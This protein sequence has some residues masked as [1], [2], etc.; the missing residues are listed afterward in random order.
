[1]PEIVLNIEQAAKWL[2]PVVLVAPGV[3]A[4]LLGLVIW[5]GGLSLR[6]FLMAVIGAAA[7]AACGFFIIGCDIVTSAVLAVLVSVIAA[8]V[9]RVFIVILAAIMAVAVGFAILAKPYF[10]EPAAMVLTQERAGPL[11]VEQSLDVVKTYISSCVVEAEQAGSEMP[12]Y[13]LAILAGLGVIF[14]IGGFVFWNSVSALCCAALG[15]MLVFAG[16]ILLLLYKGAAPIANIR[17]DKSFY[18]SVF[19]TMVL[20]GTALQLLL[21][22]Q[23]IRKQADLGESGQA[24]KEN[25]Q[26]SG[27]QQK[28]S[29]TG[30]RNR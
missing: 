21:F 27:H 8:L 22:R 1:M 3:T 15:T 7:A 12:F 18:T 25:D 2:K 23:G 10:E 5:L 26:A 4:L 9:E 14:L 16:M 19:M 30:W 17:E 6:R 11:T 24:E 13:N 20:F 28:E 29:K